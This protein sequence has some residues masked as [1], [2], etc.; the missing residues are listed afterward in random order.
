MNVE[1]LRP[2][3]T[4]IGKYTQHLLL[5]LG[6]LADV[7]SIEC[8]QGQDSLSVIAALTGSLPTDSEVSGSLW[9]PALRRFL[10]GL[11][12]AYQVRNA[13]RDWAFRRSFNGQSGEVYHE[14]NYILRPY[15]GPAVVTV[16]D[17]SHLRHPAFHPAERVTHL[18]R[19]LGCS[20]ARANRVIVVSEFVRGEVVECLGVAADKVDVT[21][22]GVGVHYRPRS[23]A[24]C[25]GILARYGLTYG[26]YLLSVA[27]MEPRKNLEGLL[28]AYEGLPV[29]LKNRW[30]LVLA[31]SSGWLS[32]GLD[33]RVD[34]LVRKG[35]GKQLG[36][37][38]EQDLPIIF[39]GAHGFAF[40]SFYEGFG[41]PLLE[42]MASG[43]ATVAS[44]RA[45]LPEVGGDVP[46]YVEPESVESIR[47]GLNELLSNEVERTR[48]AQAGTAR[49]SHFSWAKTGA[50]TVDSY[51]KALE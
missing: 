39:A 24:E 22:L 30:P 33:R 3:L 25:G 47:S 4:G 38:P 6:R 13:Y 28:D 41:L 50:A 36:Y 44:Q 11:P 23:E 48:R 26:G 21:P 35:W 17:L 42:A 43:V 27:T 32:A 10:R 14:P 34:A 12:G 19:H 49:A 16:H 1:S 31:G 7:E 5:E 40:V 8:F 9:R 29:S 20:V 2:P 51:R 15:P 46:W 45:S 37:V 18:S